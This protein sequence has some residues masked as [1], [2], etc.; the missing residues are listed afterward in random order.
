MPRDRLCNVKSGIVQA[1]KRRAGWDLRETAEF[2]SLVH[3][4]EISIS[5][6]LAEVDEDKHIRVVV[7]VFGVF[8][9]CRQR[10]TRVPSLSLA[11]PIGDSVTRE[12]SIPGRA[13]STKSRAK[14]LPPSNR[15]LTSV[16]STHAS[17]LFSR[18]LLVCLS[19]ALQR[20]VLHD[21]C[22]C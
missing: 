12:D 13:I 17:F 20:Y 4:T 6:A 22:K 2:L 8:S 5:R 18:R 10:S 7:R 9:L 21:L 1:R 14:L 11:L 16:F 3:G 15:L 19:C